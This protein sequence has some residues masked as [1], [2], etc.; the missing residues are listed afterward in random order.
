ML[1]IANCG[2]FEKIIFNIG[3]D[4]ESIDSCLQTSVQ[5]LE[6]SDEEETEAVSKQEVGAYPTETD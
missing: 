6:Y 4:D 5:L 1:P 3:D 2:I